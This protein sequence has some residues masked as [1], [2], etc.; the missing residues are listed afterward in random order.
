MP[1]AYS[2]GWVL[3]A[4]RNAVSSTPDRGHPVK[5]SRVVDQRFPAFRDLPHD[6]VPADAELRG[7]RGHGTV[8]PADLLGPPLPGPVRED[9]PGGDRRVELGPGLV[10]AQRVSALEDPVSATGTPAAG[11]SR[12]VTAPVLHPGHRTART[13]ADQIPG[14]LD[15]DIPFPV[16]HL[17][18]AHLESGHAEQGSSVLV[19][20]GLLASWSLGREHGS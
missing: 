6:R 3:Q 20:L 2:V 4:R 11:R 1:V 5:S 14:C 13:A 15:T 12:T 10:R 17:G 16:D 8:V 18:R 9:R 19:H 7:D